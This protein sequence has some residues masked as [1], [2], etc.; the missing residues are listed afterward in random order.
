[1]MLD[2]VFDGLP[3]A[4]TD[5]EADLESLSLA[6]NRLW[7]CGSHCRVRRQFK[8]SGR[9]DPRFRG[10]P[11]RRLLGTIKLTPEGDDTAGMGEA[12]PFRG[13]GSL[14]HL[15][16]RDDF[17]G[18][19]VDL[20]SK[21]N[22]LDIEGVTVYRN[23]LLLGLRGP[24]VDSIATIADIGVARIRELSDDTATIH[25]LDLGGLGVRDLTQWGKDV[26]IL[27]GPVSA[28]D[29]P[30]RLFRWCPRRA[31]PVEKPLQVHQ[32]DDASERPEG[33]CRLDRDGAEGLIILYDTPD[34]ARMTAPVT[35]PT[36]SRRATSPWTEPPVLWSLSQTAAVSFST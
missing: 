31:G 4:E 6:G 11:S 26:L 13:A 1:M 16:A 10:R 32:W 2:D 21:E 30:F 36:G 35:A 7:I 15:L 28:A 23:R 22:G 25:F 20:P 14:R 34:S 8:K 12:F 9:M 27:A 29:G 17:I 5:D 33:I 18:P 3:G 19:F 24:I